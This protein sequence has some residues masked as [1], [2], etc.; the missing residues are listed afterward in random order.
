MTPQFEKELKQALSYIENPNGAYFGGFSK[1][2]SLLD[3]RGTFPT[4]LLHRVEK[5]CDLKC[6]AGYSIHCPNP[7]KCQKFETAWH[8]ENKPWEAQRRAAEAARCAARGI[9]SMPTGTGKSLVAAYICLIF[10]VKTLIVVPSL[11]IKRQLMEDISRALTNTDFITVENI[12]STALN[13]LTGFDM[14]IIDEAH[15]VAARTYQRLNK[16][17][18]KGIYY[19]FFLTATPFRNQADE[20]L[21]FE[22]IAGKVIYTLSY[23]EA[24]KKGY[25][26]PIEAYYIEIEKTKTDGFLYR[27]VYNDLVVN[28][29]AAHQK[30][31]N[32]M[33]GLHASDK[34]ALCLVREVKHGQILS[35]I[36]GL[37]FIHGSIDDR[38]DIRNFNQRI[39]KVLIG[40]IGVLGEGVDTKPCEYVIIAGMGKA[41]STFMQCVG[42][43]LRKFGDKTSGK[44]ILIRYKGHKFCTRHFKT[45]CAILQ[46]EYGVIPV[47][48]E[49]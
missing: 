27:E 28:S 47:K 24:V 45:Q 20:M 18:W 32:V 36:S 31:A 10:R 46:E 7:P 14:L 8:S 13:S 4:G 38:S 41:K 49:V 26:V 37:S 39:H 3:K 25:I 40:T 16:K 33:T 21:L 15:H 6:D 44:V 12:D 1:R 34:S 17:A 23:Q 11:E 48:L 19:R 42:R 9:I 30:L 35:D 29:A 43:C 22:A 2:K 5:L